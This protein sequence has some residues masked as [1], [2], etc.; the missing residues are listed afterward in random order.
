MGNLLSNANPG[1]SVSFH[2]QGGSYLE[3]GAHHAGQKL[4][5]GHGVEIVLEA[6]DELRE[7]AGAVGAEQPVVAPA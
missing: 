1:L 5:M 7:V 2:A 4:G 6:G 3:H